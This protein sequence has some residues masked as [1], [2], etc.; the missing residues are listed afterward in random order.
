MLVL[1]SIPHR[2]KIHQKW[3][4]SKIQTG[5]SINEVLYSEHAAILSASDMAVMSGCSAF[6]FEN[7]RPGGLVPTIVVRS[8]RLLCPPILGHGGLVIEGLLL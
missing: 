3:Q 5:L 2:E 6:V 8:P 7:S 1:E 4:G